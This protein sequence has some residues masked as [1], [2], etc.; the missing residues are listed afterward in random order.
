MNK[1]LIKRVT[2]QIMANKVTNPLLLEKVK[3]AEKTVKQLKLPP[4]WKATVSS[5]PASIGSIFIK[6]NKVNGF[7][8]LDNVKDASNAYSMA[9]FKKEKGQSF[10]LPVD[11]LKDVIEA[12]KN[13][14]LL[15]VHSLF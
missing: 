11:T 15:K 8:I 2:R 3:E 5:K 4:N 1:E 10:I 7:F 9:I 12:I 14:Y 6:N 13:H